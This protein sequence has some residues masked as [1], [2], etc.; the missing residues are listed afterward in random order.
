MNVR[1]YN[2]RILQLQKDRTF[3]LI[4]GELWVQGDTIRYIGDGTD[5]E[6]VCGD[7]TVIVWEREIDVCGKG[8]GLS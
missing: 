5:A 1:F 6:N 8:A 7:G 3:S 2:A 4:R